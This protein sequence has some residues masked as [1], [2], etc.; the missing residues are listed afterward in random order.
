VFSHRNAG[1]GYPQADTG[2]LIHLA[3]NHRQLIHHTGIL[4][5]A[6]HLGTFASA[7]AYA[8]HHR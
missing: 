8:D 3:E 2:R 6:I 4:H 1:E 5:I 7:F